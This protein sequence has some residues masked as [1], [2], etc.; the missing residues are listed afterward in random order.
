MSEKLDQIKFFYEEA[1]QIFE[2]KRKMPEIE[3]SFYPYIGINHTIRVRNGKIFVRI[4]EICREM[5]LNAQ[6]ALAFIL[7]AK[8]FRKKIPPEARKIYSDFIKQK[9]IQTQAKDNKRNRGRKIITT[10]KGSFYDLEGIFEK[11]NQIYFNNSIPKTTLTWSVRRT[12]RILGHHDSTHE[13]IVISRSLDDK[14]VPKYVVEYV[15]FH[16]MLHIFHPTQNRNGRRYN[17]TPE[18]RRDE[19]KFLYFTEAENWIERNVKNLKRK[20]KR[21]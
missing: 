6:K 11:I 17:H 21:Q 3:V 20:A 13:T 8:L 14:N 15:V 9:E 5:P 18:F 19:G 4:C 16:E 7:V 12:F 10:S 2:S 1:F